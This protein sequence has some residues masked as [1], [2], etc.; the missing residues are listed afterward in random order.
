MSQNEISH[1][2]SANMIDYRER[3]QVKEGYRR[4]K[5]GWLLYSLFL[6]FPVCH[7]LDLWSATWSYKYDIAGNY[8]S[9]NIPFAIFEQNMWK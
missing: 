2:I 1:I 8:I 9:H 7:P 3:L 4:L 6:F 5:K